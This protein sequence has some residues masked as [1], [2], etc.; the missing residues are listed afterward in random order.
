MTV[1]CLALL[2]AMAPPVEVA[3]KSQG[4]KPGTLVELSAE[5]VVIDVAGKQEKIATGE[6]VEIR[7]RDA[8]KAPAK[9]GTVTVRL[10]DG[11][12]L[13][14]SDYRVEMGKAVIVLDAEARV[15]VS[16]RLI[17]YVRL[18]T[19]PGAVGAQFDEIARGERTGDTIIVVKGEAL[20]FVAGSAGDITDETVYFQVDADKVPVKRPKVEGLLYFHAAVDEL[21]A[22][23]AT[24]EVIGGGKLDVLSAKATD[25]ALDVLT[26]AKATLSIPWP[27]VGR[28][29]FKGSYLSD[30]EPESVAYSRMSSFGFAEKLRPTDLAY[31]RPRFN[32]GFESGQALR[33]A[34]QPLSRGLALYGGTDVSFRLSERY[35]QLQMTA[36]IDDSARPHG[37][38]ELKILGENGELATHTLSGRDAPLAIDVPLAGVRRVRI[39]VRS[40]SGGVHDR[41]ILGDP[42]LVK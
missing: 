26:P 39:V 4:V 10:V 25:A 42:R 14:A 21:P 13:T 22:A 29:Q 41:V 40:L 6:L 7:P 33:L 36:G 27:S 30:L 28:I 5:Q 37:Q 32:E 12:T 24:L 15:S 3:T 17:D 19:S 16:T 34:G 11:S 35:K 38:V 1:W 8:A 23:V 9:P 31:H 20:D 18:Q 2:V